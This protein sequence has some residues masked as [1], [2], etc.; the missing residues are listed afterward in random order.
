MTIHHLLKLPFAAAL[1][2]LPMGVLR[3][4][5]GA[6]QEAG[7]HEYGDAEG[8][9]QI[10][11]KL[12]DLWSLVLEKQ[13]ALEKIVRAKDLDRV[14]G[15]VFEIR[16]LVQA[17][18]GK[19]GGLSADNWRKLNE[20][21]GQI[22]STIKLLDEHAGAWDQARVEEQAARLGKLLA[23]VTG[24]YPPGSL[25]SGRA[26]AGPHGGAMVTSGAYRLEL[27]A[28]RGELFL[29][30]MNPADQ[31]VSTGKMTAMAMAGPKAEAHVPMELVGDHFAG[32]L[33]VP[34]T[35]AIRVTVMVA[36]TDQNLLGY[37]VVSDG[38]VTAEES[39]GEGHAAG[40]AGAYEQGK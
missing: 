3:A 28:A 15:T 26:A 24:L 16:D 6:G 22:E 39:V 40:S 33:T 20:S 27:V 7:A 25:G 38:G 29:F 35:G 37:F 1:L 2:M 8:K 32:K 34:K 21:V 36:A 18:P 4:E 12:P 17:V 30:V 5:D 19:S 14:R 31:V 11:E 10:P 13:Y 9:L 23:Y